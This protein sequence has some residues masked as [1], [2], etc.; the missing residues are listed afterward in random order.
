MNSTETAY[1]VKK[2][3]WYVIVEDSGRHLSI[4]YIRDPKW[5]I[6]RDFGHGRAFA[7]YDNAEARVSEILDMRAGHIRQNWKRVRDNRHQFRVD[8]SNGT[9]GKRGTSKP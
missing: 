6:A 2:G 7:I 8:S 3:W 9:H 1:P 5:K 4:M